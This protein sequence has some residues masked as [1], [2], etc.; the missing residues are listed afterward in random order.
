MIVC[1]HAVAASRHT[2]HRIK[3][4]SIVI[5]DDVVVVVVLVLT[6]SWSH[7]VIV[8]V[9]FCITYLLLFWLNTMNRKMKLIILINCNSWSCDCVH[10]ALQALGM[11]LIAYIQFSTMNL[12]ELQYHYHAFISTPHCLIN[13]VILLLLALDGFGMK[14]KRENCC[15]E[16]HE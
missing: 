7:A 6:V 11:T 10:C 15:T 1:I 8:F 14:R 3:Q 9:S 5:D 2:A 16:V 12:H 4:I 13:P